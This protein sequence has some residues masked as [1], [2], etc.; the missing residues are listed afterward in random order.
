MAPPRT[1]PATARTPS[2]L[3]TTGTGRA[4]RPIRVGQ[5]PDALAVTPGGSAVYV[6]GG[7]SD[8]VTPITAVTG[9]PGSLASGSGYTLAAIAISRSGAV[10]STW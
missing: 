2:P 5:A 3:I 1:S 7:D 10:A 9:S 4:G 8:A 6:T